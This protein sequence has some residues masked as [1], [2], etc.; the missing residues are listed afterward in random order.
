MYIIFL[1]IS[2]VGL[3]FLKIRNIFRNFK[4]IIRRERLNIC[5]EIMY[6]FVILR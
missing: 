4:Y 5:L 3:S 1:I 2:S 6:V